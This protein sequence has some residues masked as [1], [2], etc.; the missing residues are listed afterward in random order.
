M[1]DCAWTNFTL[2]PWV[3]SSNGASIKFVNCDFHN[4]DHFNIPSWV[5]AISIIDASLEMNNVSLT[6]L[7]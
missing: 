4:N 1:E 6:L 5:G 7:T 2:Q 3:G